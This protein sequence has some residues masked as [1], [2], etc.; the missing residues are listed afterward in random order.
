MTLKHQCCRAANQLVGLPVAGAKLALDAL[1]REATELLAAQACP[2]PHALAP[3]TI[4]PT[5]LPSRPRR[6]R[7]RRDRMVIGTT[8]ARVQR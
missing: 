2:A 1:D 7:L 4:L 3:P 5:A 8:A 6:T